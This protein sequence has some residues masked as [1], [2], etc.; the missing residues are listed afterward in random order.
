MSLSEFLGGFAPTSRS[1]G[2]VHCAPAVHG[3]RM[4]AEGELRTRPC[5]EY[6]DRPMVY[7]FYGRPAYKPLPDMAASGIAEHLP[8]CLV[9]DPK[10]LGR[11]VRVVPFDS[12]G[13]AK[14]GRLT[15]PL[16]RPAFELAPGRD[17]PQRIVSAFYET[18]LAYYQQLPIRREDDIS[19]LH[20]EARAIARLAHDRTIMD[21]DD[22]CTTIE[23]QLEENVALTDA[24][25]A[26]VGPPALMDE[27][28][29]LAAI[30]AS[31][32]IPITYQTFGRQKPS[33][34]SGQVYERVLRFFRRKRML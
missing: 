20:P 9:L 12:G 11:A 33:F 10:L 3:V 6:G 24:L 1:L 34:Y 27:P 17:M 28:A 32:A 26:I 7:L 18:N 4:L 30:R 21:D 31:G 19:L 22:R 15:D 2:L 14:Y 23:V 25:K 29:V 8:M 13:F 5:A 16:I